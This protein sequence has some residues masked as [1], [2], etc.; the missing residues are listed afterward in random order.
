MRLVGQMHEIVVAA[1]GWPDRPKPPCRRSAPRSRR[2][3]GALHRGLCRR[4]RCRSISLRV[5]CRGPAAATHAA[6]RPDRAA[7]R[8]G[9]Q[10]HPPRL[11]RRRLASKRRSMTATRCSPGHRA[12]PARRSSRSARRPPSIAPG[13]TRDR[14]CH[15]HAAHRYRLAAAPAAARIT[16]DHADRTRPRALIEADPVSLEI[17]WSRLVTVVEEMWHTIMPH[18]LLADRLGSARFRLRPAGPRRREPGAFAA[19]HAGVQPD[20]CR[21]R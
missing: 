13:D 1:A 21:A 2:L 15:R 16:A 8:L 3:R 19:R 20:R 10:G 7:S 9:A 5:R 11:V 4:R 18:R 14:R 12:S 6:P 17:M